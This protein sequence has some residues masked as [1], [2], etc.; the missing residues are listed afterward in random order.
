MAGLSNLDTVC[1]A[2]IFKNLSPLDLCSMRQ[3]SKQLRYFVDDHMHSVY[4]AREQWLDL[5][6]ENTRDMVK[7][8][9]NFGKFVRY[10]KIC[11]DNIR[12]SILLEMIATYC[13]DILKG[14]T[15][16][17]VRLY[18][19]EIEKFAGLFDNLEILEIINCSGDR[20]G[21]EDFL[22]RQDYPNL[23][24]LQITGIYGTYQHGFRIQ[25]DVLKTFFMKKRRKNAALKNSTGG[26]YTTITICYLGLPKTLLK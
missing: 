19:I 17:W 3:C 26:V 9:I 13:G 6:N 24:T 11:D 7:I 1:L 5:T 8:L 2:E 22:L 23:K 16:R 25:T 20:T 18:E 15:L 21:I 10:L 12:A 14:L 4:F